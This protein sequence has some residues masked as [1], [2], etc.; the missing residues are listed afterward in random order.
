MRV[1]ELAPAPGSTHRPKR[2]GRGIGGKGGKTAGRGTKGQHSRGRGKVA[3]GFEGGQMPLKQR[4]PKLKGFNNPF[5]IEYQAVNLDTI[6]E[7]DE[8]A[9]N[10][11]VLSAR[12][13]LHKGAL[14][15]VLAR[16]QVTR[17]VDV[18]A[19]AVSKAAQSAIE[20]AGG[21][22][23]II[24]LPYKVRPAANGNQFTNR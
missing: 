22:V 12:G 7:L 2:K 8:A 1:D 15:K 14:V 17:K 5:R 9:V 20:A 13:V 3:R 24:P 18:S 6:N 11:E 21:S 10:P 16:G 23:T 19:H 4:V